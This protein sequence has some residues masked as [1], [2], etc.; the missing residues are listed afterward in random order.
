[1]NY[2]IEQFFE[3][4]GFR[5]YNQNG[6]RG[7]KRLFQKRLDREGVTNCHCNDKLF[8]TVYYYDEWIGSHHLHSLEFE[9]AGKSPTD[10]EWYKLSTSRNVGVTADEVLII[11]NKLLAAWEALHVN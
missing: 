5:T 3:A 2:P 10:N 7:A 6:L 11:Q 4:L 9:I 1:M 8:L